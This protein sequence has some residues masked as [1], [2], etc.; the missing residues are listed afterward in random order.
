M[1]ERIVERI[2]ER[3]WGEDLDWER[4]VEA[5]EIWQSS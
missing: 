1:V 2:L 4:S 5:R 3:R